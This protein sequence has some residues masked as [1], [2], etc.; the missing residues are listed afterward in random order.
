MKK[1]FLNGIAL[2]VLMLFLSAGFVFAADE[3]EKN[4]ISNKVGVGYQG[5]V[6]GNF[7]NG[8]SVRG[9]IG[10]RIGLEASGFY[11]RG[12]AEMEQAGYKYDIK[13]DLWL[14][15]AKAMYALVARSYSKFYA[16]GKFGYGQIGLSEAPGNIDGSSFMTPGLFVGSEWSFPQ[17]PEVGFNF[18]V[19]YSWLIYNN[20]LSDDGDPYVYMNLNMNGIS[21]TFGIHYYF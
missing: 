20:K 16:G 14:V 9:W 11:G 17:L 13:G 5:M 19:G 15:E 1:R 3:A 4:F 7:L 18:D 6:A 8:L 12:S 2:A 21:A 10:E